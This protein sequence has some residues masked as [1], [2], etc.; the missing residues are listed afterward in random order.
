MQIRYFVGSNPTSACRGN[1]A[2]EWREA[3]PLIAAHPLRSLLCRLPIR[4]SLLNRPDPDRL[5]N[6]PK[7]PPQLAGVSGIDIQNHV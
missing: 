2:T 6:L 5:G 1:T 3:T 4:F 7:T